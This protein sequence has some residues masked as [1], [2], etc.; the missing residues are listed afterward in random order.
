[1]RVTGRFEAPK[2]ETYREAWYEERALVFNL[3]I[4]DPV[5]A[6]LLF[7]MYYPQGADLHVEQV[8][9]TE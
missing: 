5:V 7:E 8:G 3:E 9:Q 2:S 1:M 4:D 6:K